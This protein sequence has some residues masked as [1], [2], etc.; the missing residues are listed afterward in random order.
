[1]PH[2]RISDVLASPDLRADVTKRDSD[3]AHP[4]EVLN[5]LAPGSRA[6][7]PTRTDTMLGDG[8]HGVDLLARA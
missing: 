5:K 7:Y 2:Y 6:S 4:R 1:M 8:A 3:A